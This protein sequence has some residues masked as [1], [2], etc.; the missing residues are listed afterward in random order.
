[1]NQP[2]LVLLAA[3]AIAVPA[4]GCGGSRSDTGRSSV[5]FTAFPSLAIGTGT[6]DFT[7]SEGA[8]RRPVR[9]WYHRPASWTPDAPVVFVMHGNGRNA[10]EYH[11][12]WVAHAERHGFL[13]IT[14]EFAEYYY[15]SSVYHQGNIIG[16]DGAMVDSLR[17]TFVT[18][19]RIWDDVRVR[20]GSRRDRYRLYGHSAGSQF[21]HRM[22]WMMPDAR[23]EHA[24]PAN[25]G[26]Y[27]MP[28]LDEAY[29]Y[30]LGGVADSGGL[31][32]RLAVVFGKR[33]TVLLGEADTVTTDPTCG[34]PPRRCD[35]ACIASSAGGRF[36]SGHGAR[37]TALACRSAGLSAPCLASDTATAS[38]PPRRLT[39]SDGS[40]PGSSGRVSATPLPT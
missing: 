20:S 7:G 33:V 4:A 16:D 27:T 29:P 24:V 10:D 17:W 26:W 13:L 21:V 1:M 11:E 35:K 12:S 22:L 15:G 19:E 9:V 25:A 28:T 30:G 38:W 2:G 34:A 31:R 18:L 23:I 37:R 8:R 6:F 14:P 39:N 5:A 32:A 36:S 3:L 40:G